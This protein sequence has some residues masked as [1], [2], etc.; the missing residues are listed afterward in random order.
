MKI[1]VTFFFVIASQLGQ[2]QFSSDSIRLKLI[3]ELVYTLASDSMHG[4]ATGSVDE[5]KALNFITQVVRRETKKKLKTQ[6]FSIQIDDSTEIYSKNG[7]LFLNNHSKETILISAHYDHIGLGGPLS[8]SRKIDEVHNG[9]DDNASGVALAIQLLLDLNQNKGNK[10][11]L[12]VFYSG[13]EIGLFGSAAFE[14]YCQTK[15]K[16]SNINTVIN[17]DMVGRMDT[18]LHRLKCMSSLPTDSILSIEHAKLF[19][20][21]LVITEKEKLALLDTKPFHQKGIPCLNFT[22]GLHDD[23]HS[24]TDDPHYISFE[25]MILISNYLLDLIKKL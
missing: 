14:A 22:T 25:G 7:F 16:F 18:H 17:F 24:T 4:R 23:Y 10:N 19:D 15:K 3:K 5:V 2:A 21:H 8:Q 11:Y 12:F 1:I 9:A 20:L 6:Q 13:H